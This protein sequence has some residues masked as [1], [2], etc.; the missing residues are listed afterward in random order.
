MLGKAVEWMGSI[1]RLLLCVGVKM[2]Y[3]I[4]NILKMIAPGCDSMEEVLKVFEDFLENTD[5]EIPWVLPKNAAALDA[6]LQK[7]LTRGHMLYGVKA[8]CFA[9]CLASDDTLYAIE[10]GRY[11]VVHLTYVEDERPPWPKCHVFEKLN[12]ALQW[13]AEEYGN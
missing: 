1:P 2:R 13:I 7:E 12:E 4:I 5:S 8:N 10:D 9:R 6:E 3:D 11:A